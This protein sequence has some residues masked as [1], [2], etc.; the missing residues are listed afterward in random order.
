MIENLICKLTINGT[1][2]SAYT[3]NKENKSLDNIMREYPIIINKNYWVYLKSQI[4][5][6][7]NGSL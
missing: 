2:Y 6:V 5:I 4:L 1:C 7:N 3:L